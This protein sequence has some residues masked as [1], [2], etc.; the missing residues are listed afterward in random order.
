MQKLIDE[1]TNPFWWLS[2]VIVGVFTSLMSSYLIRYLDKCFSRTSSWWHSRSEEKKAEWKEQVDW[3][4]QSEKNLLIQSFEETRQR[5]RAIYFLLLGCLLAVLA[6]ILAQYDHPGVK[7]MVM[8]GL[9]MS[10]FNAL[11][12]TYA[13]L[14]AT[15]HREKI[16][17]AL[18]QP[19]NENK[20]ELVSVT[21]K[22]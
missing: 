14:Q 3:I 16:Y 20:I 1:L 10:T 17:Q 5:L 18:R 21:P 9:A 22:Q 2:I 13:F 7:Y 15:D 6:S 11:V 12:A 19:K 8:F 4:R